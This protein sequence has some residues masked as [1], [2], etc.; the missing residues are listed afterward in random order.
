MTFTGVKRI[1]WHIT[2]TLAS[3]VNYKNGLKEGSSKTYFQSGQLR[4]DCYYVNDKLNGPYKHYYRNGQ[5]LF[6]AD[7]ID[8]VME[9]SYKSYYLTG[10]RKEENIGGKFDLKIKYYDGDGH[11]ERIFTWNKDPDAEFDEYYPS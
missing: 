9:A 2:G 6:E 4:T 11:I 1:F 7:L 10:Q 5:L 8:G 3:E